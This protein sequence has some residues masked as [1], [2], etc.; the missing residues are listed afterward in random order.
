MRRLGPNSFSERDLEFMTLSLQRA[1]QA[2]ERGDPPIGAALIIDGT[3]LDSDSNSNTSSRSWMCHAE[4]R[5]ITRHASMLRRVAEVRK[6]TIELFTTLEPC[7]MCLGAAVF[8]RV[9]RIVFAS[10]DPVAGAALLDPKGLGE[11]YVQ[12]WPHI[13]GGLLQKESEELFQI[14]RPVYPF[15]DEH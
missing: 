1:R 7:L 4:H 12:R 11:W 9:S 3:C 14:Y 15:P 8:S 5:L 10:P 2:L 13:Q 6:G